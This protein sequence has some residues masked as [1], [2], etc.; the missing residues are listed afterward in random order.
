MKKAQFETFL[1]TKESIKSAMCVLCKTAN[2]IEESRKLG[3]RVEYCK[4]CRITYVKY[5]SDVVQ[6]FNIGMTARQLN[7]L[8]NTI[9]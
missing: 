2:V 4:T 3:V 9:S 1:S 7:R 5:V 8:K 6:T